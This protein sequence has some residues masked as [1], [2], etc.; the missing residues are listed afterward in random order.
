MLLPS[1][2]PLPPGDPPLRRAWR[3]GT[4]TSQHLCWCRA[5][6][7]SLG[8]R[9]P[10]LSNGAGPFLSCF[11]SDPAS[12]QRGRPRN[13]LWQVS[14]A[15]AGGGRGQPLQLAP[16]LDGLVPACVVSNGPELP[17]DVW[18]NLV[19]SLSP[20]FLQG[21][22]E[23]SFLGLFFLCCLKRAWLEGPGFSV[24]THHALPRHV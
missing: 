10:R 12:G 24:P 19:P 16:G 4:G 1:P 7:G 5:R 17:G 3:A 15:R 23:I 22:A 6:L 14:R 21:S 20:P 18:G 2:R 9:F 13:T 11:P 8:P